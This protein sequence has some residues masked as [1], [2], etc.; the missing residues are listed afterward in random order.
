MAASARAGS[1]EEGTLSETGPGSGRVITLRGWRWGNPQPVMEKTYFRAVP[2]LTSV[3]RGRK[4][5]PPGVSLLR[6]RPFNMGIPKP[7]SPSN[8]KNSK[9]HL[10]GGLKADAIVSSKSYSRFSLS[11]LP[12]FTNKQRVPSLWLQVAGV[13]G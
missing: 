8:E 3:G 11:Y 6:N 4:D 5:S 12:G 9:P 2:T 13:G 1:G 10:G 7:A